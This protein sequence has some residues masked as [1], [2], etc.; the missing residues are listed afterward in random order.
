MTANIKALLTSIRSMVVKMLPAYRFFTGRTTETTTTQICS[1]DVHGIC[2]AQIAFSEGAITSFVQGDVYNLTVNGEAHQLVVENNDAGLRF[3]T[4]D[5]EQDANGNES[6]PNNSGLVFYCNEDGADCVAQGEYIGAS[7]TLTKEDGT[8]IYDGTPEY[9]CVPLDAARMLN[10]NILPTVGDTYD[11]EIN[12]TV[13]QNQLSVV[14]VDGRSYGCLGTGT[15]DS[16]MFTLSPENSW[17]ILFGDTNPSYLGN[18][19]F[20]NATVSVSQTKTAVVEH[21]DTK[22]L[23]EECL[24][25][26]VAKTKDVN[27]AKAEAKSA[28]ADAAAARSAA[29]AALNSAGNAQTVANNAKTAAET[30]QSTANNAKTAAETAQSTADDAMTKNNPTCTGSFSQNRKSKTSVGMWSHAEG[31]NTT[32]SGVTAHA[33][34]NN[35][36]ASVAYSHAE[37]TNT[38]ASG[39]AA[40]AEGNNT[41]ASG[42][43]SHAEGYVTTASGG[44]AHAEGNNTTASGEQSHA[45]GHDTTASGGAAHAEGYA[46][47]ASSWAQHVQGK[48]NIEDSAKKYAHIVGNGDLILPEETV[49][50]SN[51]HTLDWNGVPW[52]QGRPQFGG[53]AQ[54]DGSQTVI[55]NGDKEIT[56]LS[57]TESSTK[58]LTLSVNDSGRLIVASSDGTTYT[59][60]E[61]GDKGDPYTLTDADKQTITNAVLAALPTWTGGDF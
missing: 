42:D 35:T 53:T 41:T 44:A 57:S 31:N 28:S 10:G 7:I 25:S 20:T 2:G 12:G 24:P 50:R 22:K 61:K 18:G 30:A 17:L 16:S 54:D 38:T 6:F 37:G 49:T 52:F 29:D 4:G 15:Y 46:T 21:Y 23:P 58:K 27:T 14:E 1:G 3:L 32:A 8:V 39:V 43:Y 26:S 36:T 47:T 48:Y 5:L 55:A 40:H 51:A 33:E 34:G 56:L 9:N 59:L 13:S 60:G 19:T 11:V 45:E